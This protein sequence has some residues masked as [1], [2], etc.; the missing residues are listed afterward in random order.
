MNT[1][2]WGSRLSIRLQFSESI[3]VDGSG[4]LYA[5]D[6][7][8]NV[9]T[10]LDFADPAAVTFATATLDGTTDTADGPQTV[11]LQNNGNAPMTLSGMDLPNA[12]F[13][14]DGDT[15]TCSTSTPIAAGASCTIGIVFSPTT[16]EPLPELSP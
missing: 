1:G 6:P 15:T 4:N 12:D 16:T 14:F 10:K 8:N 13:Q 7:Y 11:S 5:A 9:V 2:W 3:A